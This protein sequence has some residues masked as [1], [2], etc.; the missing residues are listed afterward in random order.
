MTD[1]AAQ[2]K[3][4]RLHMLISPAELEAIDNWRFKSHIAT[5]ADAIRRLTQMALQIDE[6]IEKIYRRTKELYRVLL[7]RLD[8]N[9][10]LM[11][12]SP[13]DWERIAKIDL[14][15]TGELIKHVSELNMAVHAMTAQV[16]RMRGAGDIA[17][18]K[19]EAEKI[20]SEAADRTKIFR[21]MM[22]ASEE[23]IDLDEDEEDK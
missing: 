15:T 1:E 19:A 4:E 13:I 8:V 3:S 6:P 10:E 22:K 2:K 20:K 7:S 5:R 12:K 9:K 11:D 17:D 14:A 16:L 23:G 21:W 18:L